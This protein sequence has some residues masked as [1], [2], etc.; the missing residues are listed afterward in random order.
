M[1]GSPSSHGRLGAS[2]SEWHAWLKTSNTL[3]RNKEGREGE[4][5]ERQI[6]YL[7]FCS[8][9]QTE[10]AYFKEGVSWYLLPATEIQF[11]EK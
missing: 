10:Q 11:Q 5:G 1:V 2:T 7:T 4:G 9:K 6:W 3:R 8:P